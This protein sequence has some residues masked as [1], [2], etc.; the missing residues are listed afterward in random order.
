MERVTDVIAHEI[1]HQW[2][3]NL[4]THKWWTDLWL[5]EGFST[6]MSE[7]AV[8]RIFPE[9][10]TAETFAIRA[11]HAAMSKDSDASSRKIN[12]PVATTADIRGLFDPI[13]YSKGA[14]MLRMMNGFLGE[15]AFKGAIRAYLKQFEYG[16]AVQ[17]DLWMLMTDFGH[18]HETLPWPLSVKE[19]MDSWT[20]QPGYPVVMAKK[21]GDSVVITQQ[22]F[23]FPTAKNETSSWYVPITYVTSEGSVK[24]RWLTPDMKELVLENVLKGN[25]WMYLNV[26]RT[27]YYRV[28]YDYDLTLMLTRHYQIFPEVTRAQIIDDALHLARAQVASYDIPLTFLMRM[29][30]Q[31]RDVLSWMAASKGLEYLDQMMMRESAYDGYKTVMKHIL[32]PAYNVIGFDEKDDESHIQLLQR[33]QIVKFACDFGYDRCTNSAQLLFREWMRTPLQNR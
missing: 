15:T 30:G 32:K 22:R 9:W 10:R 19:V 25:N 8:A 31:E 14:I 28:H 17:D 18:K 33:A 27:G 4:A 7:L 23:M 13:T 16:N 6:Y 2:F 26:N 12:N 1:A 24:Q 21:D 11:F 5:K 29:A 20:L 3:G